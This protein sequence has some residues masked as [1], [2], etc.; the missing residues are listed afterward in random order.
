ML[1]KARSTYGVTHS[2]SRF[3][4]TIV[5]TE[6]NR[7]V[8]DLSRPCDVNREG[9]LEHF[10]KIFQGPSKGNVRVVVS[11]QKPFTLSYSKKGSHVVING[12]YKFTNAYRYI[13]S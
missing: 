6:E 10:S 13:E 8:R 5:Y 9:I 11:A 7:V 1:K 3:L 4:Y 12:Y 2:E